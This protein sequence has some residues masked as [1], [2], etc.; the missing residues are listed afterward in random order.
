M[1]KAE[2]EV[3]KGWEGNSKFSRDSE[4]RKLRWCG[5]SGR[6][7]PGREIDERQ[8]VLEWS[9]NKPAQVRGDSGIGECE[10]ACSVSED[11]TRHGWTVIAGVDNQPQGNT[12]AAMTRRYSSLGCCQAPAQGRCEYLLRIVGG[13]IV[14]SRGGCGTCVVAKWD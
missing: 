5:K 12:S 1:R 4:H 3:W 6:K 10:E 8:V 7:G 13:S 11:N 9:S 14:G 2:E